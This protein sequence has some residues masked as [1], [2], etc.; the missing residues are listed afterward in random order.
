MRATSPVTNPIVPILPK[1]C[2]LTKFLTSMALGAGDIGSRVSSFTSE[3]TSALMPAP[4]SSA[5]LEVPPPPAAPVKTCV[6]CREQ[7]KSLMTDMSNPQ[8]C[9][10]H[11]QP[12]L[13]ACFRGVSDG[14]IHKAVPC[15]RCGKNKLQQLNKCEGKG[16]ESD[17]AIAK[18]DELMGILKTG[19]VEQEGVDGLL[20]SLTQVLF[21][22]TFLDPAK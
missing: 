9:L 2:Q 16:E 6:T 8:S 14:C 17:P 4:E 13:L 11:C 15:M 21:K 3:C 7:F 12:L 5:A 20:E 19:T 22:G 10:M 1:E 18:L